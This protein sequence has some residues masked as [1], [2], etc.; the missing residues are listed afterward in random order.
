MFGQRDNVLR[1]LAQGRDSKLELAE[2]VEKIP[3]EAS[4]PNGCLKILVGGSDDPDI[5]FDF[6]VAAQTVKRL[7]VKH[8]QQFHLSLQLKFANF[9]Q[10]KRAFVGHFKEAW[11][12]GVGAAEG[13]SLGWAEPLEAPP[14]F[15]HFAEIGVSERPA[16]GRVWQKT[17]PGCP[18][19]KFKGVLTG[20]RAKVRG[21]THARPA[22]SKR[23][24]RPGAGLGGLSVAR[25]DAAQGDM[26]K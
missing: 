20:V 7:A 10:E 12:G 18:T 4:F 14:R 11:L 15:S 5:D 21:S 8:P 16:A 26:A 25:P 9:V 19:I 13:P 23:R 2:A 17:R 6:A 24:N 1:T 22:A 3:P